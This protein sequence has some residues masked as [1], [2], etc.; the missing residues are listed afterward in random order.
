MKKSIYTLLGLVLFMTSCQKTPVDYALVSGRIENGK[1]ELKLMSEDRAF[2]KTLELREDGSFSDTIRTK[3]GVF[4]LTN[5][6][7]VTRLYLDKGN[8]I[9]INADAG[10][11]NKTLVFS[12]EGSSPSNYLA[13]KG[14]VWTDLMGDAESFYQQ[15]ET[16]YKERNKQ[17]RKVLV[18]TLDSI[19]G[20]GEDFRQKE[21]RNLNYTYLSALGK[22]Q[23]FHAHFA[24]KPD[25]KVSDGYLD[26]LKG[27]DYED[28]DDYNFSSSYRQLLESHY[29]KKSEKLMESDSLSWDIAYLKALADVPNETIRNGM[30]F[31]HAK[32]NI[33]FTGELEAYYAIFKSASTDKD[34]NAVIAESYEQLRALSE[35]NPSPK[36]VNYENYEGGTTSLD[37]LKGKYV[38]IDVWATWCGPCKA[39][40]P[41]LKEVE[42]EYR[43]K[44]IE[45]VSI[46]VDQE[47][48]Y[49]KWKAMVEEEQ[50]K[51]IQVI[52]DND[53]ESKFVTDYLIKG[54]PKFILLD[55]EGNIVSSNAPRPSSPDLKK[56]FD[57]F[58]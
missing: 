18:K 57:E 21:K 41:F 14:E 19:P 20:I 50:L 44:N 38:Y 24:K 2:S 53:W 48:D 4:F 54:I 46:S 45:F 1:G 28:V 52:A 26:E 55:P 17:I 12:G 29:R 27:V 6:N 10:D 23:D 33:T 9:I 49:D 11:F 47:K 42:E 40:I 36:F 7:N 15:N 16:E 56:M 51:G 25:F 43:D 32:N 30:L 22:Y 5:K 35:G 31:S 58:L 8:N 37:D 13:L 34:N 39:E 3:F